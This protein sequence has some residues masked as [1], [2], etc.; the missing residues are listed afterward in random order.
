MIVPLLSYLALHNN[1]HDSFFLFCFITAKKI[2]AML[3]WNYESLVNFNISIKIH[4]FTTKNYSTPFCVKKLFR[5]YF[6]QVFFYKLKA[7]MF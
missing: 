3:I 6:V 2:V 4:I 7:L 5:L 1:I